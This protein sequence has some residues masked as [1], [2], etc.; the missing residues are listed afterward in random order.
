MKEVPRPLTAKPPLAE[1]NLKPLCAIPF[2][3]WLFNVKAGKIDGAHQPVFVYSVA[4]LKATIRV[5]FQVSISYADR[6]ILPS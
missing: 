1:A 3:A 5:R 6:G 4:Q 2:N